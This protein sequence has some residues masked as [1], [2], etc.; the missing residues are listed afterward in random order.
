M[1]RAARF[2][3]VFLAVALLAAACSSPPPVGQVG[4][5][6]AALDGTVTLVKVISPAPVSSGS[7]GPAYG[8]KLV[9]VV[10]TVHS[11][12]GS[13]GKFTGIYTASKL[14]DSKK[15]VHVGRSTAKYKVADCAS[16]ASFGTLAPGQAATGC[17]VFV[18]A[19]AA[20]PVELK[21][22][23]KSQADWMI[24]ASAVEPGTGG[25]A[26]GAVPTT[27]PTSVPGADALGATPTTT[28][29]VTTTTGAQ[30][31]TT[32]A[33]PGTKADTGT[34]STSTSTTSADGAEGASTT[35]SPTTKTTLTASAHHVHHG[36][37]KAPKI[38]HAAPRG[39]SVGSR[40][41]IMGRR[42]SGATEVTFNGVPAVIVKTTA[43]KVVALVP[44]GA[45]QGYIEVTT[46]GGTAV[47]P[48]T[49]I[50][51]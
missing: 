23:G 41:T 12:A 15:L 4:A 46:A 45:T 49:F 42:L 43:N 20:T 26:L 40:V 21:I 3:P 35:T 2:A 29:A 9:A 33:A 14:I 11:P 27:V 6:L 17:V 19:G 50:V 30:S 39:A 28:G 51:L 18:L 38:L 13:A 1:H 34:I 32:T 25:A 44:S 8:R 31:T 24:A 48:R 10:L 36:A 16:Y 22:S 37:T 7:I 47:S 5:T